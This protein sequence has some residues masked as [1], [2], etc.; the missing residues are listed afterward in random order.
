MR[1]RHKEYGGKTGLSMQSIQE[2]LPRYNSGMFFLKSVLLWYEIHES[3][4]G[5]RRQTLDG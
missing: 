4:H 3:D 5:Y 2:G 1:L